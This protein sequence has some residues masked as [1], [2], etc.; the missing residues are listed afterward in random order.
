MSYKEAIQAHADDIA[1]GQYGKD[2][3]DLPDAT[4]DKIYKQAEQRYI[5]DYASQIDK[6]AEREK[7]K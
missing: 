3:Y 6:M 4:Q 7:E 1:W 2:F 5:D